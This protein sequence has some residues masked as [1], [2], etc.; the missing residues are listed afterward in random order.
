MSSIITL[1]QPKH[2]KELEL[3]ANDIFNFKSF[4]EE[5]T[6]T[7]EE[8]LYSKAKVSTVYVGTGVASS[9]GPFGVLGT[10]FGALTAKKNQKIMRD[11]ELNTN[12][13]VQER[14]E[15]DYVEHYTDFSASKIKETDAFNVV[16]SAVVENIEAEI[17]S[18]IWRKLEEN[19]KKFIT[20]AEVLREF[21]QVFQ[22]NMDYSPPTL[23]YCKAVENELNEKLLF[24]FKTYIKL[25]KYKLQP[26][27]YESKLSFV[28]SN[29][30]MK[31][32]LGEHVYI[33]RKILNH[34]K[35]TK[36]EETYK[37]FLVISDVNSL[38]RLN[39]RISIVTKYYRN[40][41]GHTE[42]M[43]EEKC[44]ECRKFILTRDGI[45]PSILG[46]F[47]VIK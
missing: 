19:S 13:M 15:L 7:R 9:I 23:N 2:L 25:K 39:E 38:G 43:D 26:S 10:L 27:D 16:A 28:I 24:P 46:N 22:N 37:K 36:I 34:K 8:V 45:L 11:I 12:E 4:T 21:L 40:P 44:L 41:S 17:G 14:K 3:V 18:I 30:N 1:L 47:K 5:I 6:L 32:T 20:T 42:V 29:S 35:L 31:L 33:L